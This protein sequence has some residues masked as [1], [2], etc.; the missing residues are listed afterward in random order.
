[1][2]RIVGVNYENREVIGLTVDGLDDKTDSA[3]FKRVYIASWVEDYPFLICT[4]CEQK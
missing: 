1:M 4:R 2:K 3:Y